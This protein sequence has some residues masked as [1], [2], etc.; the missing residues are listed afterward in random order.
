MYKKCACSLFR[1]ITLKLPPL[2][3]YPSEVQETATS[4]A[5]MRS[6]CWRVRPGAAR[7]R[8]LFTSVLGQG[9]GVDCDE[10][11][12]AGPYCQY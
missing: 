5:E 1:D 8:R 3:D 6:V 4:L 7:D 12:P 9:W 11:S 10:V 2:E